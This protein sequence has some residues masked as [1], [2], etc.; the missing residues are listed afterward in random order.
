MKTEVPIQS[1]VS[2]IFI[3]VLKNHKALFFA[4]HGYLL[5]KF[6]FAVSTEKQIITAS[7]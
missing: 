4:N 6:S 3:I 7:M 1:Y 2:A 5:D